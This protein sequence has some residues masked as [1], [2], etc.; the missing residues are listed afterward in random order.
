[1]FP[2]FFSSIST[3]VVDLNT[4]NW[5]SLIENR[6][7]TTV[8]IVMFK[9]STCPA[10][11]S[12][13]PQFE[14]AAKNCDGMIQFGVVDT[15][16]SHEISEKYHIQSVPSFI[17]FS[18]EGEKVYDGPRNA[19]GFTNYPAKFIP[20]HSQIADEKWISP[21][22][23]SVILITNKKQVPPMWA[24]IS[25]FFM[26]NKK[27]I[28]VGHIFSNGK[29]EIFN[30]TA[31]PTIILFKGTNS[32][33]YTGESDFRSI[34]RFII[35]FFDGIITSND[36]LMKMNQIQYIDSL[37]QFNRLCK[38]KKNCI[39]SMTDTTS[40][41]QE[42]ANKY[43]N[44]LLVFAV[45]PENSEIKLSKQ[46]FYIF[47]RQSNMATFVK[48]VDQLPKSISKVLDGTIK[49]DKIDIN[50]NRKEL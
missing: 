29:G 1:M 30:V 36:G 50:I 3:T 41:Y 32:I 16:T 12:S 10:C 43:K 13:Y 17:I 21:K 45:A 46:G 6:N 19:R 14:K 7:K 33:V 25:C 34:Q 39:V 2:L 27:G 8:W 37:S 23:N 4:K 9:S 22:R 11:K 42:I 38:K 47:H 31:Y 44:Q 49:W 26:K 18:P 40:K 35:Q 5:H 20:N 24:A 48:N 15:A 28:Q